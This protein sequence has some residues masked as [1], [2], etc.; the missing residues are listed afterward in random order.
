MIHGDQPMPEE[1]AARPPRARVPR[2]DHDERKFQVMNHDLPV[3]EPEGLENR[4]L[5]ALKRK[6]PRQNRIRHK[7]GHTQEHDRKTNRDCSQHTDFIRNADVRGMIGAAKSAAPAVQAST[8]DPVPRSR[9]LGAPGRQSQSQIVKGAVQIKGP[10]QFFVRHPKDP[11][12]PV[13]GQSRPRTRFEDDTRVTGQ[14]RQCA[15]PAAC[16]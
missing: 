14:C 9:T 6:Q 7:G 12:G 4:D 11:V 8:G 13:V 1:N 2:D 15:I 16:H 3:A 5:F 10:R